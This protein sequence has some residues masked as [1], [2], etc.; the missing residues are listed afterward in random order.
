MTC[1]NCGSAAPAPHASVPSAAR[2]PGELRQLRGGAAPRRQV[3]R[4]MRHA[5][6]APA[7]DRRTRPRTRPTA[8]PPSAPIAERRLV[9]ILFADLVG[10]TALSEGRDAEETRELLSRYFEL[11]GEVIGRYG[12]TIEKFIGDAVMAVWGAPDRPRE[13]R[14]ARRPRRAGPRRRGPRR[15][16]PGSTPAPACSPARRR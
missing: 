8:R 4:G 2:P 9:S 5:D 13:R 1:S 6:A 7:A 12:G 10:F 3:L 14:R 16:A 15:S 11:A